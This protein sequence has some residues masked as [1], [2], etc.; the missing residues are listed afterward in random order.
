[1]WLGGLVDQG[2]EEDAMHAAKQGFFLEDEL[3]RHQGYGFGHRGQ[4]LAIFTIEMLSLLRP[5]MLQAVGYLYNP[6]IA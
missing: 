5:I 3:G 2:G 4:L 1:M 6:F